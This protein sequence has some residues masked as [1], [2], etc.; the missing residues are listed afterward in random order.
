MR[1]LMRHRQVGSGSDQIS[2]VVPI[3]KNHRP[4]RLAQGDDEV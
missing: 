3:G 1:I 2:V 4:G